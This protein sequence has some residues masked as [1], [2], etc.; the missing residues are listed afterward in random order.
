MYE[1]DSKKYYSWPTETK[2]DNVAIPPPSTWGDIVSPDKSIPEFG[3]PLLT[4]I[5]ALIA[6]IYVTT[7]HKI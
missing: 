6:I 5:P 7:R 1:A 3:L 2:R 4:M